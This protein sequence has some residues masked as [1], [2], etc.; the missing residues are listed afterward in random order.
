MADYIILSPG[1]NI[2]NSKFKKYLLKFK[3]KIITDLDLFYIFNEKNKTIVITGSNGKS[4][5]CKILEQLLKK[6]NFNVKMGG[7]IGK[8]ILDLKIKKNTIIIIEAS[9]YQLAYS[10]FVKPTYSLFLNISKDHLD[11]HGN[12]NE[13]IKAKLKIFSLQEKKD[14][15]LIKDKKIIKLFRNKKFQSKLKIINPHNYLKIKNKIINE[16]LKKNLNNENMS[17]AYEISKFF[18]ITD[19]NFVKTFSSFN[20]LPHRHEFFLKIKNI[21]F[22]NDS[23]AT[24][25]NACKPALQNNKKIIWIL[26]GQPKKG[27]RFFL[28]DVKK[29]IIKCFII[30]R[31]IDFF[32]KQINDRIKTHISKKLENAVKS[33][34]NFIK[35]NSDDQFT[36][37]LSPASASFDQYKNFAHRGNVFKKLVQTYAK[38]KF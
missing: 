23:K 30:G 1:I 6:N 12:M 24:N 36:V 33:I 31:H 38:R 4:T 15:A 21:K 17:F 22:I 29:N 16:Y 37:L 3:H 19:S 8:S 27:D 11:W 35:N 25:F 26:G 20:G 13:Y 34:F 14:I 9:S 7:N 18:N 10:K 28:T 32:K 5:T 2:K